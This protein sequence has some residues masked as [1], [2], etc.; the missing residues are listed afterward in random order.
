MKASCAGWPSGA[1][2][3][4]ELVESEDRL[5]EVMASIHRRIGTPLLTGLGLEPERLAIEPGEVVPRRFPD[6]FAGSPAS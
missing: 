1:G 2:G 5:D 6:L 4:C 3:S